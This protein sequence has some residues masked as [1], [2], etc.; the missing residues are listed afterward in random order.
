V[1]SNEKN[2]AFL[3]ILDQAGLQNLGVDAARIVPDGKILAT[4][5]PIEEIAAGTLASVGLA[6]SKVW[7]MRGGRRQSA[8]VMT[9]AAGL[10]MD[11]TSYLRVDGENIKD[12][13]RITGFYRAQDGWVFLHGN[14]PH[15]R[16]GLLDLFGASDKEALGRS[17][18]TWAAADVEAQA[19]QR[20]LCTVVMRS[21]EQWQAHPQARAI[22]TLPLIEIRKIGEA[23]PMPMTGGDRPLSGIRVLDLTRVISGPMAGRTLAEH[24][25]TVMLVTA[26]HLPSIKPLVIDTGFGK[27]S[28]SIDLRNEND[29]ALLR[30]LAGSAD[31]FIDSYRPG[32]LAGR[33]FGPQDLAALRPG[34]ISVGIS[35]Y[36]RS[37]P[38]SGFR[39]YDSLVQAAVGLAQ[40]NAAGEPRRQPC[41]PL[42][43]LTGYLAAFGAMTALIRRAT[44]GGS[45]RVELSLARTAQWLWEMSDTIGSSSEAPR[46]NPS[47][48]EIAD[49]TTETASAFGLL[50][51]LKPALALSE[52]PGRWWR[53][54][55]PL[56]TDAARW[57]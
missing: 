56:G 33:G 48:E 55:V 51:H 54:P 43:Y 3:S 2:P 34:I 57:P 24:G 12:K 40:I 31:I 46:S 23:P 5:L 8:S 14:F 28:S 25:A 20:G 50:R 41:Q 19:T 38:W 29:S 52:T 26:P 45:W 44:E 15:L 11:S 9:R 18:T 37:G 7:E 39:G 22:A 1:T 4:M 47:L 6:V 10:A 32:A 36:S 35:A 53:A 16:A 30:N 27:L 21:R 49:L 42:D 13:D 17:C